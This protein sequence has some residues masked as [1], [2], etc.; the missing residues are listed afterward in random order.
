MENSVQVTG[1]IILNCGLYGSGLSKKIKIGNMDN[2]ILLELLVI[3][4]SQLTSKQYD[5]RIKH[6]ARN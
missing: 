3:T 2:K 4:R 6:S 1:W 5:L